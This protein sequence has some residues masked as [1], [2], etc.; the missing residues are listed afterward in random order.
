MSNATR[1]ECLRRAL[2][3]S[4]CCVI[5]NGVDPREFKLNETTE[6]AWRNPAE[7]LGHGLRGRK[8]LVTVG[9]LVKRK[10]VAW[11]IENVMPRVGDSYVYVVVGAGPEL[12]AIS[13]AVSNKRGCKGGSY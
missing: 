4:L 3:E 7:T 8:V 9:R 6:E 1:V 13:A 5:P 10:G 2:P 11:Y 12:S